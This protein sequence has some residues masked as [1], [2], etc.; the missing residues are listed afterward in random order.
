MSSISSSEKPVHAL[1]SGRVAMPSTWLST[2]ASFGP[3]GREV[4]SIPIVGWGRRAAALME[5]DG[6]V[7][8]LG[9]LAT[10]A[11]G[12]QPST[13]AVGPR[14]GKLWGRGRRTRVAE[15]AFWPFVLYE[16]PG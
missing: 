2:K 14:R 6:I 7:L 9:S 1:M 12:L 3:I 15:G 4:G 5:E 10:D 16:T 11:F 8:E 13:R